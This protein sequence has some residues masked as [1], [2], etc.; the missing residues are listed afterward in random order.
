MDETIRQTTT[1]LMIIANGQPRT[2]KVD[3]TVGDL[4][5]ELAI[6]PTRVVVQLDGIIIPRTEF[7]QTSLH[8]GC[9]LEIIT[10]VGGG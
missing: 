3:S 8:E 4:L 7:A 6:A 2:V 10:M 5:Q 9:H 1:P